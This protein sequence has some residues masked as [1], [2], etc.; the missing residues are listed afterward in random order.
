MPHQMFI[1][2]LRTGCA[3]WQMRTAD[4][5]EANI[6][7]LD[8]EKHNLHRFMLYAERVPE[9]W[10][11]TAVITLQAF[12]LVERRGYWREWIPFMEQAV[13]KWAVADPLLQAKILNRLGYLY[14]IERRLDK[15]I[16][17]HKKAIRLAKTVADDFVLNQAYY[18]L[19]T[20]YR[21][22]LEFD[23]AE[24]YVKK[25]LAGFSKNNEENKWWAFALNELGIVATRRG[26]YVLARERYEAAIALHKQLSHPTDLLRTYNNLLWLAREEKNV[27]LALH[28]YQE[29]QGLVE[30]VSGEFDRVQ[31]ELS[32]GS[33]YYDLEQYHEAEIVFQRANSPYL[34][35][36]NNIY[37]KALVLQCLGISQLKQRKLWQ[38]E[39]SLKE[40]IRLWRQADD[41]VMLSNS[42][43]TLAECLELKGEIPT[44]ATLYHEALTLLAG[45]PDLAMARRLTEEFEESVKRISG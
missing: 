8:E 37:M 31:A 27:D 22:K 21:H 43:G 42:L 12:Y 40:S 35:Q 32:L 15:A 7:L 28:Y 9:L 3:Y 17:T 26:Q 5:S 34:Q 16:A 25:A 33:I 18:F 2:N 19:G 4:E 13:N 1:D 23:L 29:M 36:S 30:D 20:D 38:A 11:E 39:E 24:K 6:A 44:A 41:E 14:Q 45:H 10:V